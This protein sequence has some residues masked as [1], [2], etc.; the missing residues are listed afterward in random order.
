MEKIIEKVLEFFRNGLL[1]RGNSG[2]DNETIM[3][4]F[5]WYM[6]ADG[7]HWER[8]AAKAKKLKEAGITAVWLPPAYKGDVGKYSVGYDVYDT[9]DLG[10]FDRKGEV[11]TKYGTRDQYLKAVEA[12][13]KAGVQVI[14]DIVI[15]QMTG[16][17]GTEK[18]MAIE[19]AEDNREKE[20][21]EPVEIEA[22]TKFDFP[23]RGG[24]YS[25]HTWNVE[26]FTGT[27]WDEKNKKTGIFLFRGKKWNDETDS[28]NVNFDYLMGV[29]LDNN[30]PDTIWALLEWGKWYIKTVKPDGLRL[31]AVKHINFEFYRDWLTVMRRNARKD[32]FAVGEYWNGDVNRLIHYIDVVQGNAWPKFPKT[33]KAG[34]N[35]EEKIKQ[36]LERK[37]AEESEAA[38]NADNPENAEITENTENPE[39][40]E[41]NP[42][43]GDNEERKENSP[44]KTALGI[45]LPIAEENEYMEIPEQTPRELGLGTAITLF[46]V[47]LHFAF[48]NAA[49]DPEN[50][51]MGGIFENTLVKRRPWNA[52]TFV[53]NHDTQ[54]GQSLESFVPSWFKPIAY[55]LILLR[56]DGIPCVFYGDYYGIPHDKIEP[57]SALP[58]LMLIRKLCAYDIQK[59]YFDTRTIVGFTRS[60]NLEHPDS[61]LAVVATSRE[62]GSKYMTIGEDKTR[63]GQK[64]YDA[65]GHFDDPVILDE[66][67]G[68]DFPVRGGSVSVYVSE[69]IYRKIRTML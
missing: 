25:S 57:V 34:E 66:N 24:K 31:D 47:P 2:M 3:Q 4:Y 64:F 11:R 28:E 1:G 41:T 30:N 53:D 37:E 62:E 6:P 67:N 9:Y 69:P 19:T 60:G 13:H 35:F 42:E 38:M 52:V 36:A 46:D 39:N 29:N 23:A 65:L 10:E 54:P 48:Y 58:V 63:G 44:E 22:W 20:I 43:N 33:R 14:A 32:L 8:V 45:P 17:D 27:D 15:N 18:I 55:A 16:A 5:E 56:K 21:S 49:N 40:P 61:G 59:D 7:L 68:A 12:L 26:N 50:F 51:D